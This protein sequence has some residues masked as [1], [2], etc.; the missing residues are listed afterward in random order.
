[1]KINRLW[2]LPSVA[3]ASLLGCG[4]QQ[5]S[6]P[7]LDMEGAFTVRKCGTE[8]L[9]PAARTAVELAI[10]GAPARAS[11]SVVVPVYLHI[12]KNTSGQGDLT[13]TQI[14]NQINVLNQSYAGLTG[15]ANVHVQFV[16]QSTDRTTNNTWYTVT[17]GTTAETNMKNSLRL[18]GKNALNLYTANIGQG[19]LGWATFPSDYAAKPKQDGVVILYSSV[20]GGSAAPYNLG[21]TATHEVGHW[22]GLYHTFQGGCNGN[23]DYVADTP[24]EKSS[25]FGCPANRDTCTNKPGLDPTTNFMDYTDDACMFVFSTGQSARIQAQWTTYRQ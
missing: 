25:A 10:A 17:P 24:A 12:I 7:A 3:V 23:G 4:G 2:V 18:G 16:L 19:L 14:T 20:P 1:M 22:L 11:F 8:D 6:V 15:G 5:S 13:A 21:D 9:S